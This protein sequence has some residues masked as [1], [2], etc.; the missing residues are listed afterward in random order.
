[1]S[2][3]D[4]RSRRDRSPDRMTIDNDAR[5]GDRHDRM[6][7]DEALEPQRS[8]EGWIVIV[9]NVHEEADEESLTERFSEYGTV[10]NLH[11]NLDR[12]TG[13][14]KGYALVEY[15]TRKEAQAAI[16]DANNSTFLDQT[17]S[18]EFAFVKG[19]SHE[20]HDRRAG[21]RERSQS[22]GAD[23]R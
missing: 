12:R 2:D 19:A 7:E 10:K 20:K 5:H 15:E 8:I 14:V 17:I 9:R 11:L 13:Y 21:R 18:V 23:R 6:D 4:S 16:D 1:M 22:P 3:Q